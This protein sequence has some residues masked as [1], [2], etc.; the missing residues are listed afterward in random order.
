MPAIAINGKAS[1][2]GKERVLSGRRDE[3][4]EFHIEDGIPLPQK[5]GRPSSSMYP[6]RDLEVGQS[7]FIEGGTKATDKACRYIAKTAGFSIAT[8]LLK[9]GVVPGLRVW[10]TA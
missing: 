2:V 1:I 6:I 3:P 7:F 5:R 8:R 10:R 4:S 9:Q